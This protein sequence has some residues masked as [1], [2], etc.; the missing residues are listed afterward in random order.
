VYLKMSKLVMSQ[1]IVS[2]PL[3]HAAA[4]VTVVGILSKVTVGVYPVTVR[5]DHTILARVS[6][7]TSGGIT[8][9][10]LVHV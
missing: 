8:I 6:S 4:N 10:E 9:F 2:L 3:F 7:K 5:A 1:C